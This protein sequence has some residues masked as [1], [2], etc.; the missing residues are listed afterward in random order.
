MNDRIMQLAS[1]P[2]KAYRRGMRP[3]WYPR[4]VPWEDAYPGPVPSVE[5][6]LAGFGNLP[7]IAVVKQDVYQDLYC[8][9]PH[10]SPRDIVLSTIQRTGPVGLFTKLNADFW[11]VKTESDPECNIWKQ[12][13]WDC[14]SRST[15]VYR[16][17]R[18]RTFPV[19]TKE[20][21]PGHDR[22]SVSVADVDWS[23]YDIVVGYECPVPARITRQ[24]RKT[25]WAYYIG[26]PCMRSYDQSRIAPL[27]GYDVFLSQH[28]RCLPTSYRGP[29]HL[30][31]FPYFLQYYGC[32]SD[33]GLKPHEDGPRRGAMLERY[34]SKV[35][36]AG[37]RAKLESF[38]PV[39]ITSGGTQHF[40]SNLMSRKYF[41]RLGGNTLWGNAM[42][43]AV[44][45]GC[46]VIGNPAEFKHRAMFTTDTSVSSFAEL[47]DRIAMFEAD[48]DRYQRA[49]D[50]QRQ[51]CDYLCFSRPTTQ[52]LSKMRERT[53]L[54]A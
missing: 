52:L 50:A 17:L 31:D 16:K 10:S 22:F 39:D 24:H 35:L 42:I 7:K 23:Q 15:E 13:C 1:F 49:V 30:I 32:Y 25:T 40:L 3:L 12:K 41:L 4:E 27:K 45:A 44:A 8:C 29:A 2:G 34:T 28:F 9:A 26:E 46:L 54:P 36:P 47:V 6:A 38:G 48:H 5:E 53:G 51:R 43:E 20:P 11:I 14:G 37:E 33:L 19:G 21:G 18:E